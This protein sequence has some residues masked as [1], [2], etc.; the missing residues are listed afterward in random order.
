MPSSVPAFRP[1]FL[2]LRPALAALAV[3]T[4]VRLAVAA[5]TPLAPDETYYWIWSR[6][7]QPGY[8]DA[9]PMVA[10]WIRA[11]TAVAGNTPLGIRLLGPLSGALGSMLLWHAAEILLPGR[12]A[13]LVAAG[14]L[15]A[16]LLFGVGTVIMT[17][18]TPLLFFWVACLWALASYTRDGNGW[19]LT[20]AAVAAG[21]AFD[22]KYTAAFLLLG[23][24]PWMLWVPSLRRLW[25]DPALY[26]GILWGMQA[27]I[28]VVNWNR[29]HGWA[30][31]L[32]QGG[33]LAH[34][35][36]V[37]ALGYLG[38]LIGTQ[39]GLAT[40]LVFILCAAGVASVTRRAWRRRD[41]AF[42]LLATM[43]LPAVAVFVQHCFAGR[44]QGNWPAVI[45][46]AAAIAAASL[47]G[48]RW[49]RL[50]GP[51]A[52]L[53]LAITGLAYLQATTA[54]LPVPARRD[55]TA[56][57]LAG[58]TGLA[59]QVAAARARTGAAFVAATDYDV[60][61]ELAFHLPPGAPLVGVEPRWVWF[62]LPHPAILGRSGLLVRSLRRSGLP[63]PLPWAS[64]QPLGTIWRRRGT[65]KIEGF[66]LF[67]VVAR[68]SPVASA[69]LP[70][71]RLASR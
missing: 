9:P 49:R 2:G 19:W 39:F 34:W 16:S 64:M 55:P 7:L 71:A 6:V 67:R 33:R 30:S 48:P 35:Q 58:W 11:G 13:G 10:L 5:A 23:A 59:R 32:K 12:R 14:L 31:F 24:V 69:R 37:H 1:A 56:L 15:N 41:P 63:N 53:G 3:L 60:A 4:L 28:P 57:R 62:D 25:R 27:I 20:V 51:A 70:S 50:I 40:P 54:L 46:P 52:A 44:V 26:W 65:A 45:Y 47:E 8:F 22:S 36:P 38:E 61:S 21:A 43:T 66:R 68:Q 29:T 17:P 42:T 18:D